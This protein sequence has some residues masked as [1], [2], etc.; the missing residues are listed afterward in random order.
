MDITQSL[1][2]KYL[3]CST[4]LDLLFCGI[5]DIRHILHSVHGLAK[6]YTGAFT[7]LTIIE[8]TPTL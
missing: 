2:A 6:R 1:S 8:D 3:S 4:S 5:S 7:T